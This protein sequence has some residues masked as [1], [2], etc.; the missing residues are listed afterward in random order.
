MPVAWREVTAKLD[1][2]AFKIRTAP[3]RLHGRDPWA[4]FAE[5]AVPLPKLR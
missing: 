1:P 3:A 4:D 5:A 2:K